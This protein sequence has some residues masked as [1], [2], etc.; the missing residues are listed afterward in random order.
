MKRREQLH[1]GE[2]EESIKL[3]NKKVEVVC[4]ITKVKPQTPLAQRV[5]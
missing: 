2:K 3:S 1:K 4:R 5:N